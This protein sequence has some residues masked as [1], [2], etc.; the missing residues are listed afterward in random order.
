MGIDKLLDALRHEW[1]VI[2]QAPLVFLPAVLVVS[3]CIGALIYAF[4]SATL[5]NKDDLIGTLQAKLNLAAAASPAPPGSALSDKTQPNFR[6]LLSGANVFVPDGEPGLTGIILDVIIT[7][8][9]SPSVAL[10]WQLSVIPKTGSPKQAQLTKMPPS[11]VAR[12]QINTAHASSNESLEDL[13]R[14]EPLQPD[15]PYSG[16][17]LF[18]VALPKPDVLTGVFELSVTDVKGHPFMVRKD[19]NEWLSR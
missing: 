10:D 18:Y 19:V 13:T 9:G 15:V 16:K 17:L 6:M 11:L 3:S 1:P 7:N 4:F 5:K 12:G 2:K 14:R 8:T